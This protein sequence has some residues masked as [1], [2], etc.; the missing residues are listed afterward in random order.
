MFKDDDSQDEIYKSME[1][2]MV[3][4]QLEKKYAF[5]KIAKSID[6]LNLA[7]KLFDK[8][9]MHSEANEVINVVKD[10][11]NKVNNKKLFK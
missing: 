3:S 6:Y 9:G 7:T 4:S 8:A 2:N 1:A 5:N 11:C 10:L